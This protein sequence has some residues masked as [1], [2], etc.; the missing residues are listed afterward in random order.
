MPM[1]GPWTRRCL[2]S[3]SLCFFLKKEKRVVVTVRRSRFHLNTDFLKHYGYQA[4]GAPVPSKAL[5]ISSQVVLGSLPLA[6]YYYYLY[7]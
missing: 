7:I 5:P 6:L 4:T 3:L 2:V 1:Y